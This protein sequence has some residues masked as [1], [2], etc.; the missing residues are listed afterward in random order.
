M[1]LAN[2]VMHEMC[3]HCEGILMLLLTCL[4]QS[5]LT[6]FSNDLEE[7][8]PY[9]ALIFYNCCSGVQFLFRQYSQS[10]GGILGDDMGLGKTV[11]TI[12]FCAALLGK[13]GSPEDDLTQKIVA[14]QK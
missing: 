13:T 6:I 12:A 7:R 9:S 1:A 5:A 3:N 14:G 2:I 4:L 10:I 8:K 11:Q